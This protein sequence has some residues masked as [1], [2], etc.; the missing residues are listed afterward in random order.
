M[1]RRIVALVALHLAAATGLV[2][3]ASAVWPTIG[4]PGEIAL[5]A[6]AFALVGLL[7]MHLEL[8]R[9][10]CTL[11]LA[12]AVLVLC[13]F[14]LD[15][16]GVALAA[17]IGETIACLLHRQSAL[18]VAYNASASVVA[19]LMAGLTFMAFG[20]WAHQWGSWGAAL[21]AV[22]CYAIVNQT[23]TSAVL[24]I[25][26]GRLFRDVLVAS[27]AMAWVATGVS[28]SIGLATT[29]LLRDGLATPLL[30]MPMV[31][32]VGLETRRV[33]SH[34]AE[35]LRFERLY[36]ASG[37]TTGLQEFGPALARSAAEARTLVTGASAICCAPDRSGSWQ[38]MLAD[39]R[40]VRSASPA[41]IAAARKLVA[42]H[43][44]A[45]VSAAALPGAA[46]AVL[47]SGAT[48][49]LAGGDEAGIV[50]AVF[51]EIGADEQG[52]ARAEVLSAF[53]GHAALTATN[54]QLYE[55]V[56]E[57]LR[58][59]VDLNRQKDDFLAAVSHE[60]RTPLAS[61]L[62]S[63]STLARLHHRMGEDDRERFFGMATRQGKRLQRLIE[64]LLLTAAVEQRE[65]QCRPDDVDLAE[66]LAELRD[67]LAEVSEGR[68]VVGCDENAGW[69]RTDA[70]KLR[71]VLINLT[72]NAA[73]YAPTGSIEVVARPSSLARG[74][75]SLSVVDHGPGI[76]AADRDRVFERFVQL[77]QSATR[78]RG[79]TGLGLYLCKRLADLLGTP[80]DL[81]ET[82]GGG[83]T[84]SL[85]FP[86]VTPAGSNDAAMDGRRV[87]TTG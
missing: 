58:H 39:D 59:Q 84:F 38:G 82:P 73:K 79:G 77:D 22:G 3:A 7:P 46:R 42:E 75:V 29:M 69:V 13:L 51:R 33:A 15:P 4:P 2:V 64:E 67:D 31:V 41:A 9:S 50:L 56:E 53:I 65:E 61:M 21:I 23:S 85:V 32:I 30:L 54:A 11:G 63:V 55:E 81:S 16:L 66:M 12:E 70:D 76:A 87:S 24:T 1:T 19:S 6:A 17:C 62:G 68:I 60:L 78:S 26:E 35:H 80:L 34:R 20:G 43:G 86:S 44:I 71:Q 48:V 10:A 18:K 27:A 36:A 49:V 72:E 5:F 52:E 28:A 14:Q 8:G 74:L 83:C 47:P 45:E 37:R 25:V 57:A 40:G